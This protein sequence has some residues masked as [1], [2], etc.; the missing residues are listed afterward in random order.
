LARHKNS[1][2]EALLALMQK[3][4]KCLGCGPEIIKHLFFD[5]STDLPVPVFDVHAGE[6]GGW[7]G[8][9]V[10]FSVPAPPSKR[11]GHLVARNLDAPDGLGLPR[12]ERF[13]I[14]RQHELLHVRQ[15]LS[16]AATD[17]LTEADLEFCKGFAELLPVVAS[18][19]SLS[20]GD[21]FSMAGRFFLQFVKREIE[22]YDRVDYRFCRNQF[23]PGDKELEVCR[24]AFLCMIVGYPLEPLAGAFIDTY[25]LDWRTWTRSVRRQM[26]GLT[27]G[28][29]LSKPV[30]YAGA[31]VTP[32][33][34]LNSIQVAG[35]FIR[36]RSGGKMPF[37]W[38]VG[39]LPRHGGIAR[40]GPRKS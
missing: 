6:H 3:S 2:L 32:W 9:H 7:D 18:Q 17:M 35:G 14:I 29:F 26:D 15:A 19:G 39:H 38:L 25:S 40:Y 13:E 31:P 28:T 24:G 22:A 4:G 34:L 33:T 30:L 12:G 8:T 23:Q 21:A 16:G 37:A 11:W 1:T 36:D 20:K 27:Q 10:L 5:R